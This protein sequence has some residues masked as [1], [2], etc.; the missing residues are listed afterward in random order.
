MNHINMSLY[1]R[2]II[3]IGVPVLY[4]VF[5]ARQNIIIDVL[6]LYAFAMLSKDFIMKVILKK[7]YCSIDKPPSSK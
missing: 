3:L 7:K 6:W 4:Y 1:I 2:L 5:H